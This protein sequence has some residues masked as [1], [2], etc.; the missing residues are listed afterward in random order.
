MTGALERP[1]ARKPAAAEQRCEPKPSA[2]CA[3]ISALPRLRRRGTGGAGRRDQR[4]RS[5]SASAQRTMTMRRA[6]PR[7][8]RAGCGFGAPGDGDGRDGEQ[9]E[10]DQRRGV[11]AARQHQQQRAEQIDR[12]RARRERIDLAAARPPG[13]KDSPAT[14]S[15]AASAKPTTT[16]NRCARQRLDARIVDAGQA[17]RQTEDGRDER[18]PAPQPHARE[19]KGRRRHHREI[20]VERPVVRLGAR[21]PAPA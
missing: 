9:R 16:W 7:P 10:D 2:R 5:P 20:D 15:A 18:Q 3:P 11:V 19:R 14:I 21:Q 12:Q 8:A 13:R 6:R 4:A 1:C 17:A